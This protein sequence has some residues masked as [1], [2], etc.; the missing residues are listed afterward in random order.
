MWQVPAA[1]HDRVD[2]SPFPAGSVLCNCFGHEI[3]I[4]EYVLQSILHWQRPLPDAFERMRNNDW[5]YFQPENVFK[6][7]EAHG[8]TLGILGYGKIGEEV[9]KRAKAFGMEVMVCN[10]SA[11]AVGALVDRYYPLD[12]V[13]EL[14]SEVDFLSISLGLAE[15]TANIIDA[16]LLAKMKEDAVVINV[17]RAGLVDESAMYHALKERRIR[18]AVLDPQYH[19][20][21]ADNPSPKPTTLDFASLDNALL[22]SHMSGGSDQLLSRR[23]RFIAENIARVDRGDR[24]EN[25]EYHGA[26]EP[27]TNVW[28]AVRAALRD[29]LETTTLANLRD[30]DL[31][32]RVAEL[33]DDPEAWVSLGRIRGATPSGGRKAAQPKVSSAKS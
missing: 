29:I 31:P 24:P 21:S 30:H 1:G 17:G 11:V 19:Y 12:R 8:K 26:A 9:A 23:A 10:R 20:P 3:P 33:A 7:R 28:I 6:V 13:R 27:L 25:M 2:T 22:T 15:Q 32:P 14:A 5:F 18:G 16:G 4:A